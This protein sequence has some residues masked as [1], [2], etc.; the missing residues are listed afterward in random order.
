VRRRSRFRAGNKIDGGVD[1]YKPVRI[2]PYG[3]LRR[4][5][6]KPCIGTK[7]APECAPTHRRVNFVTFSLHPI[8]GSSVSVA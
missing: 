2:L 7:R 3:L 1:C 5:W 6:G 8:D 4:R